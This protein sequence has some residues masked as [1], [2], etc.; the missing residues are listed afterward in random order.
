MSLG[1]ARPLEAPDLWKLQDERSSAVIS[2]RILAS[3]EARKIEADAYNE[4]LFRGEIS[5]PLTKKVWWGIRGQREER[6]KAWRQSKRKRASLTLAMNDAVFRWFWS[7]GVIKVV[8]DTAQITSP[9][10]VKVGFRI[11]VFITITLIYL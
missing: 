11:Y 2:D 10:V 1:Y 8:S 7:S 6:E 9:L 5:P 4:R 3:F